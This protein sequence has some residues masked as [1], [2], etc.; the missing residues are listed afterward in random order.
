[1]NLLYRLKC[2][3]QEE[4]IIKTIKY[5]FYMCCYCLREFLLNTFLDLRYSGRSLN[6]NIKTSY[7]KMGANDIYHTKYS[8]LPLIFRFVP[9]NKD[10]VLVDVGCGKGRVIIYWL[11]R[12]YRNK[13]VGLEIDKKIAVRTSKYFTKYKN[14]TIIPGNAISNLP[15]NGTIFYFYNPFSKEIVKQFEVTLAAMYQRKPITIIYY[16]P[17]SIDV[18]QNDKWSTKHINFEIDLGYKRWGRINKYHELAIIKNK[19]SK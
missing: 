12:R 4:G 7:K 8:A 18:F 11:S 6:G 14:V 5:L 16:N 3:Q 10:D 19:I 2:R 17:K 9:V 15:E 1:M 13:I